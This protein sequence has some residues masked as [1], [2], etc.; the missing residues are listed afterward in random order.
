MPAAELVATPGARGIPF[1]DVTVTTS[2][3]VGIHGWYVPAGKPLTL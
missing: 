1:E 2:D 3:G